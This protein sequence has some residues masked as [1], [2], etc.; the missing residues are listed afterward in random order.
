MMVEGADRS[1][2]VAGDRIDGGA[3]HTALKHQCTSGVEDIVFGMQRLSSHGATRAI[4][5]INRA[6]APIKSRV[7]LW[8]A[9]STD[10]Q[11]CYTPLE[12]YFRRIVPG[13]Y[14]EGDTVS[15]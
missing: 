11:S 6:P 12:I 5:L 14:L 7:R 3:V 4:I 9:R 13:L 10:H 2:A 1:A 15:T 8:R